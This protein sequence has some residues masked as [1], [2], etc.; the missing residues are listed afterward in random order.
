MREMVLECVRHAT[1]TAQWCVK[2]PPVAASNCFLKVPALNILQ[3]DKV[4]GAV[5]ILFD[6]DRLGVH[7]S[8]SNCLSV[9]QY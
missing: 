7:L 6:A 9:G 8:H 1:V 3:F 4:V 5:F 2:H